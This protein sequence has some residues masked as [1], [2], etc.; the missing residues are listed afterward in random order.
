[1]YPKIY[2]QILNDL[3]A[4][5]NCSVQIVSLR[6]LTKNINGFFQKIKKK[7]NK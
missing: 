5:N 2:F 1:M 7:N 4:F 3:F 6:T